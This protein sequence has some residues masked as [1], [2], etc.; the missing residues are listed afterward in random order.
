MF[1]RVPMLGQVRMQAWRPSR[2]AIGQS[3][4]A[5]PA[6]VKAVIYGGL[7]AE[8]LIAGI[9]GYY[10]IKAGIQEHGFVKVLGWVFGIPAAIVGTISGVALATLAIT[11]IP[12]PGDLVPA[13]QPLQIPQLTQAPQLPQSTTV[14]SPPSNFY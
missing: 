1:N 6:P 11:G 4:P 13:S 9:I 8:T 10:G 12:D 3:L 5:T 7:A 14:A 2:A